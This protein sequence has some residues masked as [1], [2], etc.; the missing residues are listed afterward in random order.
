M[1]YSYGF[2][3]DNA[4]AATNGTYYGTTLRGKIVYHYCT[5]IWSSPSGTLSSN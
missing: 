1:H 3:F 2:N 5:G 4:G